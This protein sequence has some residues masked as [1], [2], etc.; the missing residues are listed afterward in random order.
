MGASKIDTSPPPPLDRILTTPW[1]PREAYGGKFGK[2]IRWHI[3]ALHYD[4]GT[5]EE[6]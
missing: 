6:E 2:Y 4:C 3:V 1:P 5:N